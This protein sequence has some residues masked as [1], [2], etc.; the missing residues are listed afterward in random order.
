MSAPPHNSSNT[1][2]AKAL[3][4][5]FG[6]IIGLSLLLIAGV[7]YSRRKS[8]RP[9]GES[10][11]GVSRSRPSSLAGPPMMTQ[12]T[13]GITTNTSY[14]NVQTASVVPM[15]GSLMLPADPVT[16]YSSNGTGLLNKLQGTTAALQQAGL[17][18][19]TSS[20]ENNQ[21]ASEAAANQDPF[22]D[23]HETPPTAG[24]GSIH[25]PFASEQSETHH[26]EE[27]GG[28]T[29]ETVRFGAP[30]RGSQRVSGGDE[31]WW[32]SAT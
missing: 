29:A 22:G 28:T 16:R 18:T 24:A 1:E 14:G 20:M 21:N 6:G 9:R 30:P 19:P 11:A 10:F 17:I 15:G 3:G 8:P 2:L 5:T 31:A 32:G 26:T 23:A 4:G 12:V 25:N 7:L 13:S 27:S